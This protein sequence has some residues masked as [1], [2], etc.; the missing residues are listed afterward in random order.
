MKRLERIILLILCLTM[1]LG[2][3]PSPTTDNHDALS[4][5]IPLTAKNTADLLRSS[6]EPEAH[7]KPNK[8]YY[9]PRA[10]LREGEKG[11]IERLKIAFKDL[12]SLDR[13]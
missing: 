10:W 4:S 7:D 5:S 8:K 13:N 12:N 6:P 3:Q 1:L 11:I 9:D 2:C